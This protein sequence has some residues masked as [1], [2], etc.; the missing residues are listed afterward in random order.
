MTS[1]Y[2][3]ASPDPDENDCP[4]ATSIYINRLRLRTVTT[5]NDHADAVKWRTLSPNSRSA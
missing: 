5:S 4:N 2:S 3:Q 1:R